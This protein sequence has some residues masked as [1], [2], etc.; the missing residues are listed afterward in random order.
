MTSKEFLEMVRFMSSMKEEDINNKEVVSAVTVD[1]TSS[2]LK[3]EKIKD[4][5]DEVILPFNCIPMHIVYGRA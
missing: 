2:V 4:K 5:E 1:T 3:E